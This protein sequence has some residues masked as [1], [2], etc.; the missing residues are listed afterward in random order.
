MNLTLS[1]R[2]RPEGRV[3]LA[4]MF[5]RPIG[6]QTTTAQ[7]Q[8]S[9]REDLSRGPRTAIPYASTRGERKASLRDVVPRARAGRLR[10]SELSDATVTVTN[11][12]D[13]SATLAADHRATD[14][15]RG[16]AFLDALAR[17]LQGARRAM[18]EQ[19]VLEAVLQLLARIAPE[20]DLSSIDP[21][22]PLQ[23]ALPGGC[24]RRTPPPRGRPVFR[25]RHCR[26]P[27]QA[28]ER[29]PCCGLETFLSGRHAKRFSNPCH[30]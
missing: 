4:R 23:R 22:E 2:P 14:G 15:A 10:S 7:T 13:L 25:R 9:A 17:R 11:L 3:S 24:G 27:R 30:V 28:R 12:G 26:P 19:Q 5:V 8:D 21:E 20:A 1:T 16:A 18:T 29:L 6:S